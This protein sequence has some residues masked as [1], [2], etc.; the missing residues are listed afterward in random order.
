MTI[1]YK[2]AEC[3]AAMNINDE[4]AGTEGNCPRCQ[5]QFTVPVPDSVAA[6]QPAVE[7]RQ[8]S[9]GHSEGG[10]LSDDDIGAFLSGDASP[11]STAGHRDSSA[12]SDDELSTEK[13]PFDEHAEDSGEESESE[14]RA[15]KQKGKRG[16]AA[17]KPDS[18]RS[19]S[20]A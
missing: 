12:D 17:A 6:S 8:S 11:S 5:A 4:L 3:G 1:R 20:I 7:A 10:P 18:A 14:K 16:A 15:R 2:C 19:A 9:S 13:N